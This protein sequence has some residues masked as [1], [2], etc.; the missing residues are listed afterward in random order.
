[1]SNTKLPALPASPGVEYTQLQRETA[2]AM[3]DRKLRSLPDYPELSGALECLYAPQAVQAGEAVADQAEVRLIAQ[4]IREFAQE[5]SLEFETGDLE[6]A[7]DLLESLASQAVRA[8]EAVA[9]HVN[10]NGSCQIYTSL[11]GLDLDGCTVTPLLASLPAPQAVQA[12]SRALA[13]LR[14]S[15]NTLLMWR[16]VAPAVSLLDHIDKF[17]AAAPSPDGKAEQ[18]E[19]P[20]DYPQFLLRKCEHCGCETNAKMRACCKAGWVDDKVASEDRASLATQP[21]ASNAG[22]REAYRPDEETVR[23]V[24]DLLTTVRDAAEGW[25][26]QP[27]GWSGTKARCEQA[28]NMLRYGA[29]LATKPPAG[30]QKP[31]L[32]VTVTKESPNSITSD[33]KWLRDFPEGETPLYLGPQLEQVA[34]DSDVLAYL[35]DLKDDAIAHIWPDDLERCQTRECTVTVAS[36]RL[37]SP[38]GHTLPLFSRKQVAD[39]L[40]AARAQGEKGRA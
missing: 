14:E 27:G 7:A 30:E 21:T 13:L 31:A 36:V 39:A 33:V 1:M 9:W 6:R 16:D 8:G 22:E 12:D 20:S 35:D 37:G 26:N 40:R 18:A 17:L 15:R 19:A 29:A 11:E 10:H 3:L 23:D 38:N 24:C 4:N 2:Y 28:I 34:Q 25:K 5:L 32:I